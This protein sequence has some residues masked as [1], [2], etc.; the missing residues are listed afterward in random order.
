MILKDSLDSLENTLAPFLALKQEI[1]NLNIAARSDDKTPLQNTLALSEAEEKFAISDESANV[2]VFAD[3]D[4]FKNVNT[5][6]GQEVGDTAITKV[7][8][9]IKKAFVEN[10]QSEAFRIGGDEF[11]LLF[12]RSQLNQFKSQTTAFEECVISFFDSDTV[13]EKTFTV[14]VSFGVV[15]YDADCDFRTLRNRAEMACKKAKTL[16]NQRFYDWTEELER[17]QMIE[18][19]ETCSACETIIRCDVPNSRKEWS[20]IMRCPICENSFEDA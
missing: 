5:Q 6:Y 11:I 10:F 16:A 14:K 2:I 4:K 8:E 13:E 18:F 1:D 12:N 17:N 19:R 9:L 20:K 7:G 15:L 3:I